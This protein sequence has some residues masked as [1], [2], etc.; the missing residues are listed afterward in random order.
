M[1]AAS[2]FARNTSRRWRLRVADR[3]AS[4]FSE[5]RPK[6]SP[7]VLLEIDDV[8]GVLERAVANAATVLKPAEDQW[9]G[10]RSGSIRDPF[11]Y[12]CSIHTVIEDISEAEIQRRS[13]ELGLYPPPQPIPAQRGS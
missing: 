4:V 9:W 8:E 11:G 3:S 7:R 6:A 10:V 12:R 13:D 5:S 1:A 2:R